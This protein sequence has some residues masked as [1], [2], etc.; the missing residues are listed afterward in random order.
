MEACAGVGMSYD[1]A[2]Q[3]AEVFTEDG[4]K[5]LLAIR[6]NVKKLIAQAGAVRLQEAIAAG[7]GDVWTLL[8]C[9]DYMVERRELFELTQA[10]IAAQYRVFVGGR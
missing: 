4:L 3:R 5:H 7:S 1:Y 10:G 9:I 8:A 2:T 6:D